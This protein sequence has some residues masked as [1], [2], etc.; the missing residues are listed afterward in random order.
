[1]CS[2]AS[3]AWRAQRRGRRR[4]PCSYRTAFRRYGWPISR[5]AAPGPDRGAR[6][7]RGPRRGRGPERAAFPAAGVPL[8]GRGRADLSA[9][10]R[11]EVGPT[12]SSEDCVR[13]E[14]VA[15]KCPRKGVLT[16]RQRVSFGR[17]APAGQTQHQQHGDAH[18]TGQACRDQ[19]R[20]GHARRLLL[21][22]VQAHGGEV[23]ILSRAVVG[24]VSAVLPGEVDGV[25]GGDDAHWRVDVAVF[26]PHTVAAIDDPGGNLGSLGEGTAAGGG[27]AGRR[28]LGAT[29]G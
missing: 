16:P 3:P 18:P 21:D 14:A 20:T 19:Y 5:W 12:R 24:A 1:M 25:V 28:V 6:L 13:Y 17:P 29:V 23:G 10:V 7:A 8:R 15:E 4:L 26:R 2:S 27:E 22:L 9:M 11:Q